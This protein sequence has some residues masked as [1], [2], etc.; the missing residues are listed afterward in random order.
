MNMS[1][2]T[3]SQG[4]AVAEVGVHTADAADPVDASQPFSDGDPDAQK[5][6]SAVSNPTR[7]A[8][9]SNKLTPAFI[10]ALEGRMKIKAAQDVRSELMRDAAA[11]SQIYPSFDL[12]TELSASPQ[13]R[14]L[15]VSG[16]PLR[17]AYEVTHL[18]DIIAGAMRF[19]SMRAAYDTARSLAAAPRQAENP[20]SHRA[21]SVR[22]TNVNNLSEKDIRDILTDVQNGKKVTF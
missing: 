8:D 2:Q 5:C 21:A 4:E 1:L 15:V 12:K 10:Q 7:T 18:D 22:H 20:L 17:Q 11:L 3:F 19:A 16:I 9:E 14:G 6:A 13:F